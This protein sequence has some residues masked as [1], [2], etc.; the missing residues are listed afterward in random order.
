MVTF[1]TMN[2]KKIKTLSDLVFGTRQDIIL[3]C[4]IISYYGHCSK[5]WGT[6]TQ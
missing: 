1:A 4:S 6:V 3:N 5:Y 2:H